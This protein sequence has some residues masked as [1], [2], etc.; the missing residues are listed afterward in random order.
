M[1][2]LLGTL[3]ALGLIG[4][5]LSF[6]VDLFVAPWRLYTSD[7]EESLHLLASVIG[8]VGAFRLARGAHQARQVILVGLTLNTAATLAFGRSTLARPETL[9][10]LATWV[11]L[12]ALTVAARVRYP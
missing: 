8:L 12:A 4:A 5:T 3:A 1:A 11:V 10:P 2:I 7:L 9:L 6:V